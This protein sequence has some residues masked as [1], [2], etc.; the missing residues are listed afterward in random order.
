M[1]GF[2]PTNQ[3]TLYL[4]CLFYSDNEIITVHGKPAICTLIGWIETS[5][6]CLSFSKVSLTLTKGS[7]T[8]KSKQG[9][10][11]MRTFEPT[12]ESADCRSAMY[13]YNFIIRVK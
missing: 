4:L 9:T 8:T 10:E 13:S 6:L 11:Q 3:N 7:W 2:Y 1:T 12:N 5:C